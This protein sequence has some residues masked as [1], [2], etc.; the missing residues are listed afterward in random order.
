MKN[1]N[2]IVKKLLIR[3]LIML[4]ILGGFPPINSQASTTT[5]L[6]VDFQDMN[7][8]SLSKVSDTEYKY[9]NVFIK[10][11]IT[12]DAKVTIVEKVN[13]TLPIFYDNS[14]N[15]KRFQPKITS[16]DSK[17]GGYVNFKINFINSATNGPVMLENFY[18]TSI[19]LDGSASSQEYNE[20]SGFSSYKLDASTKLKTSIT[21]G[22]TKF[23]GWNQ[24]LADI[25]FE[26]TTAY[27][28]EYKAP[29]STMNI[30]L[31]NTGSASDRQFS[32]NFG[33]LINSFPNP[34]ETINGSIPTINI[35]I[36]PIENK[37]AAISGDTTAEPG[38]TVTITLKDS[39][40]KLG[41]LTTTVQADGYYSIQADLSAFADGNITA[42]ANVVNQY[43]NPAIPVTANVMKTPVSSAKA[44]TS[45]I[46]P[47]FY[48][49]IICC[50]VI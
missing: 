11:G 22:R 4:L 6:D 5:I 36:G 14:S 30:V 47:C 44:I 1:W 20:I 41:Y 15:A 3:M 23:T 33:A 50:S 42:T 12:V 17:N 31:G 24:S 25:S 28:A 26:K 45:F 7:F 27:I 32:V 9:S 35:S 40:N 13:A 48:D 2:V 38:Q 29:V 21:N 34:V 39:A 19:D 16:T 10:D 49:K 43:G 37:F 46:I 8:G 18:L